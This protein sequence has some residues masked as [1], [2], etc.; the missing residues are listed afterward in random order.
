MYSEMPLSLEVGTVKVIDPESMGD[1][2]INENNSDSDGDIP[3]FSDV[4][5]M[6]KFCDR[7]VYIFISLFRFSTFFYSIV[8]LFQI[9]EMDLAHSE[10]SSFTSEGNAF[11]ANSLSSILPI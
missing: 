1:S 4:E 3:Y 10:E 11:S 6:V 7:V 9:L 2:Y 8:V 5:A